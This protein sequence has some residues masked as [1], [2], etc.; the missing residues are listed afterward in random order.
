[1]YLGTRTI[2]SAGRTSGSIEITLPPQL[3]RLNGLQ[4]R[5]AVRDGSRPEIVVEPNLAAARELY[6]ILWQKL[7]LGLDEAERLGP[8]SPFDFT[9][10]LFPV[11]HWR[12][13]PPL[14]YV[15]AL[16]VL[17]DPNAESDESREALPRLLAS[18]A[19]G[20]GHEMGLEGSFAL[21]F[22]DA[23]AYLLTGTSPGLGTDFERAMAHRLFWG[24]ANARPPLGSPFDDGVWREARPGLRRVYDQFHAWEGSPN[25]YHEA[26]EQWYRALRLEMGV[27]T[28]SPRRHGG[29]ERTKESMG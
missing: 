29:V 21:A 27:W 23:L 4:C 25:L 5:V 22:G 13:R 17:R 28:S 9:L 11:P 19:S 12:D 8:F 1:M 20:A 7:G 15:D 3:H 10:T 24:G 26:R 18:L 16:A 2:R 6:E 14:A